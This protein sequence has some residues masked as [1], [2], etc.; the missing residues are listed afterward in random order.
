MFKRI[1]IPSVIGVLVVYM[2]GMFIFSDLGVLS[3]YEKASRI[4][5]QQAAIRNLARIH[6]TKLAVLEKIRKNPRLAARYRP[7]QGYTATEPLS[8]PVFDKPF[9]LRHP[10]LIIL[11]AGILA[12]TGLYYLQMRKRRREPREDSRKRSGTYIKPSWS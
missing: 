12:L 11:L 6:E 2:M 3:S 8:R 9:L 4:N 1:V 10:I 5:R 7:W